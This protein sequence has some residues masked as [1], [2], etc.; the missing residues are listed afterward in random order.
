ML[1]LFLI[2]LP[3]LGS[4]LSG[5]FSFYIGRKGSVYITILT[6]FL[7]FIFSLIFLYYLIYYKI[8]Y[9]IY[10]I[11]WINSGLFICNWCFLID[12]LTIVLLIT[13]TS[14]STLVH[15]YSSNYML[16]DPHISRFMSYLSLFTFFMIILVTSNNFI[17]MFIGWEG[18]GF[19]SYLLINFWFTRL[20]ANKSA[21]KA[22]L[23]NKIS[24]LILIIG[25]IFIFYNIKTIEYY[26][27]FSIIHII[28]NSKI[29]FFNYIFYIIDIICLLIFIGAIGKSAQIFFH[30]WLPDAMEGPTPVSALIHAATMV[31]AGV[32]LII[33]CSI[34]FEYSNL[35]LKIIS[36]IGVL[37]AFFASTVSL[38]QNDFKKII[39]YSTCSQLGYMFFCCGLSNYNLAVFHL[40]NHAYF[41]A[42]LF[43]CSGYIIHILKDEQDIRKMGGLRKIIPFT[44][45]T[46]LIG[47]LS[48]IGFPFLSGFY[49]KDFIL[50]ISFSNFN[51]ISHFCYWL[52][53]ISIFLTASY[54]I[55]LLFL[56]FFSETNSYKNIIK[57]IYDVPLIISFIFGI[58]SFYSIFIG[59]LT[60]DLFIGL[61][62]DFWNNSIYINP[63]NNKIIEIEFLPI[64]IKL[65]PIIFSF[66]SILL[67][68]YL[69]FFKFNLLYKIKITKIG[70]Y[71][72]NFL[73]RKWF[74]DKI[75]IEFINQFFLKISYYYIYKIIDKGIIEFFGPFGLI[76]LFKNL[77]KKFLLLQ[78]GYIYNYSLL[79]LISIIF[80]VSM[81]FYSIF[82]LFFDFKIIILFFL[83]FIYYKIINKL[84]IIK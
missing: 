55:R 46:F 72:Y 28:N 49:S 24:D 48:L 78:T 57:N 15:I 77:N 20:Q 38:V 40:S 25:I 11:N 75:Y 68:F 8:E 4:I 29:I 27:I 50:E 73:N 53:L 31:T 64:F 81:L 79:I 30:I 74:F 76:L 58:L 17:Q 39:A 10:L 65:L 67:T 71:F 52:G 18:V 12:S 70:L 63:I 41:K 34:F 21:I 69:Y 66:S 35:S 37:T 51:Q 83:I 44:Y 36:I 23:L 9:Y 22:M 82:N 7:S 33:R 80:F 42:L 16:N 6:T 26:N 45:I 47:S 84:K 2:F 3:F 14:I 43:L 60:K 54:S 59:Y 56:V 61:G 62:S 5:L 32:Y 19:C 13:I 1:L